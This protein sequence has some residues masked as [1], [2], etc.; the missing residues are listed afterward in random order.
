MKNPY[1]NTK[2]KVLHLSVSLPPYRCGM[3]VRAEWY[4]LNGLVHW[5]GNRAGVFEDCV[6]FFE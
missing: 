6:G 2:E 5:D 3:S 4:A 1:I